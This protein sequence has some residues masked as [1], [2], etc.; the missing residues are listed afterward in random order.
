MYFKSAIKTRNN[1]QSVSQSVSQSLFNQT[2]REY[3]CRN[4][5]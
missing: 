1:I 4:V 2:W 3:H 5:D